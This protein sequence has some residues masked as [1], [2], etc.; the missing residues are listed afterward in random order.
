MTKLYTKVISKEELS[1]G[2]YAWTM[3]ESKRKVSSPDP[4]VLFLIDEDV[5]SYFLFLNKLDIKRKDLLEIKMNDKNIDITFLHSSI[6]NLISDG[7]I[8]TFEVKKSELN[9][10]TLIYN[11]IQ[12]QREEIINEITN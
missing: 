12:Q 5:I 3:V 1:E 7:G 11:D 9:D 6:S 2:G 4:Q 8:I 10:I